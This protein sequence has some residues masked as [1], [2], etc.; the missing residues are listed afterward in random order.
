MGRLWLDGHRPRERVGVA[1]VDGEA[2]ISRLRVGRGIALRVS[3]QIGHINGGSRRARNRGAA[4]AAG[5]EPARQRVTGA[6]RRECARGHRLSDG[7]CQRVAGRREGRRPS[8]VQHAGA[9]EIA[10]RVGSFPVEVEPYGAGR[11]RRLVSR[12]VA[13]LGVDG[14]LL[15]VTLEQLP[16]EIEGTRGITPPGQPRC[17]VG[18]VVGEAIV[19]HAAAGVPRR[20]GHGHLEPVGAG[21]TAIDDDLRGGRGAVVAQGKG[22]AARGIAHHIAGHQVQIGAGDPTGGR[23]GAR[24]EGGIGRLRGGR[25]VRL[26]APIEEIVLQ[27]G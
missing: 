3:Q 2:K 20:E 10:V 18:A 4:A 7:R 6:G 12:P 16:G 5:E 24:I 15:T 21:C 25:A 14:L 23:D 8:P 19:D 13:H 11:H 26:V 9:D 22:G 1:A 17:P 27:T